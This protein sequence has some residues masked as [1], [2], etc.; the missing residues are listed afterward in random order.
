MNHIQRKLCVECQY[1]HGV[2]LKF[3]VPIKNFQDMIIKKFKEFQLE[4]TLKLAKQR[5]NLKYMLSQT[6]SLLQKNL[7]EISELIKQIYQMIQQE[8]KQFINLINKNMNLRESC[9]SDLGKLVYIIEGTT[10]NDWNACKN[11]YMMN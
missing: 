10:Q 5:M 9:F 2:G 4:E 8:N 3:I 1:V 6:E 7:E 11:S